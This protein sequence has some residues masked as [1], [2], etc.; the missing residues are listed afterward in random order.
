MKKLRTP[1]KSKIYVFKEKLF[2]IRF[3]QF[4]AFLF[5]LVRGC[6]RKQNNETY[7]AINDFCWLVRVPNIEWI[8]KYPRKKIIFFVNTV[9]S[10]KNNPLLDDFLK[11]KEADKI[12]IKHGKSDEKA[13][14]PVRGIFIEVKAYNPQIDEKGVLILG[15]TERFAGFLVRNNFYE[16]IKNYYIVLEPSWS[17]YCTPNILMFVNPTREVV[18]Q[19][20]EDRDFD[21]IK[22]LNSNLIPLKIGASHWVDLQTFRPLDGVQ[23]EYDIV[24]IATWALYKQHN[25][26]FQALRILKNRGHKLKVLLIGYSWLGRTKDDI[27]KDI[28]HYRI[29]DICT[30]LDNILPQEVNLNLNKSKFSILLSKKEGSCRAVA[31]SVAAGVPIMIYKFNQGGAV[32]FVNSDTGVLFDYQ[33]LPEQLLKM[34]SEWQQYRPR[35]WAEKNIGFIKSTDQLNFLL[36]DIAINR[37]EPWTKDILYKA[38]V[39]EFKILSACDK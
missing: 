30:V 6:L 26:L 4:C 32:N 1:V 24:Y 34:V 7:N 8:K 13:K 35:K 17:G 36:K 16:I 19:C 23:K 21:F 3:I 39:P 33:E 28:L 27:L 9:M 14:K 11:S 5:F 15:Y 31:E 22:S 12:R 38:N 25:E 29:D 18:V 2:N 10:S 20:P 37:R